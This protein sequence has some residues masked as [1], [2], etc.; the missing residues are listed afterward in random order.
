MN[1]QNKDII[2]ILKQKLNKACKAN[3]LVFTLTN[4]IAP[5]NSKKKY[6]P[7]ELEPYD[8]LSIRFIRSVEM[9][10]KAFR[11]IE[12]YY[13]AVSSETLRDLLLK[14]EKY[15]VI[16]SLQTWFDMRDIRNRIVHDYISEYVQTI[17]DD[18]LN[19]YVVELK[20][21]HQFF[22]EFI[23]TLSE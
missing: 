2:I 9:S 21:T 16:S 13:E 22:Q 17:F 7:L 4:N 3:D 10:L 5:Y 15:H 11:T 6:T 19:I 18:I 1:K 20:I 12:L 14:M 8:A 23:S